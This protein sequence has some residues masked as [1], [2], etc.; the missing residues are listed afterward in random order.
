MK[1]LFKFM[2]FTMICMGGTLSLTACSDDEP[3]N[4]DDPPVDT[5]NFFDDIQGL[6]MMVEETNLSTGETTYLDAYTY[7]YCYIYSEDGETLYGQY[8][9]YPSM[10]KGTKIRIE[11]DG[12]KILSNGEE[13]GII[14]WC[15][16]GGSQKIE[17]VVEWAAN[18]D[19]FNPK[20]YRSVC[21]YY[22]DTWSKI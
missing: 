2:M 10:S 15:S 21:S 9:S 8:I 1:F 12:N 4:D 16:N 7:R 19:V 5:I 11:L 20:S 17:L 3:K 13:I 6:W 22:R 18:Q 14:Q